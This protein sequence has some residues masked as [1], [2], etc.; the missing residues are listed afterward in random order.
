MILVSALLMLSAP[1]FAGG[2]QE[3]DFLGELQDALENEGLSE[4]EAQAVADAASSYDWSGMNRV[5]P[6][7]IAEA[8]L[9][10]VDEQCG[11]S[12]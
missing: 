12:R 1:L 9:G 7:V 5:D 6:E 2:A 8:T 11:P 10:S 3:A 4:E